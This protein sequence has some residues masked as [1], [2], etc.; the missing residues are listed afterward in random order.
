MKGV[1]MGADLD[2]IDPNKLYPFAEAARLLPSCHPGKHVHLQSLHRWRREGRLAAV[3]RPP[4]WFVW[5]SE[6][7]RLMG[8]GERP[9]FT[10]RTPAQRKRAHEA[11]MEYLRQ[12]GYDV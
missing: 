8:A 5:G 3:H 11:A 9:K 6:L 10:G 2:E 7:L 12:R 1:I 4:W